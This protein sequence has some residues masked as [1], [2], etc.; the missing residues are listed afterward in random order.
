[1]AALAV[2][3]A[4]PKERAQLLAW[5]NGVIG[6]ADP[7]TFLSESERL[8]AVDPRAAAGL[9]GAW[10]GTELVAAGWA[11][12]LPGA[13]SLLWPPLP[14]THRL[15]QPS[16]APVLDLT[17]L[18]HALRQAAQSQGSKLVQVLL[19]AND[20]GAG[21]ILQ[22]QGYAYMTL[23]RYLRRDL[24]RVPRA[25]SSSLEWVEASGCLAEFGATL[26]HTYE[27]SL[28]CPELEG[29]RSQEEVLSGYAGEH[30]AAVPHWWLLRMAGKPAGVIMA[31]SDRQVPLWELSYLGLVP[32]S[33][34][35]G[36]GRMA[37]VQLLERIQTAGGLLLTTAVDS[38]N[39]PA[40]GLYAR[41]GMETFDERQVWWTPLGQPGGPASP[42]ES[43]GAGS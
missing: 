15:D 22:S 10:D 38:R 3:A 27:G 33:R 5:L 17:P 9:L 42:V 39:S 13:V 18:W 41:L 20:N 16:S 43:A 1:M 30:Q 37:M 40:C 7:Q 21:L 14:Q 25:Q 32:G 4:R 8:L 26:V 36:L 29:L 6:A 28:D 31:N 34:G 35:Q 12:P 24:S 23:M 2:R 11:V 19:P